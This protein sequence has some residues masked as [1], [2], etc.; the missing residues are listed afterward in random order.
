MARFR[1]TLAI[2]KRVSHHTSSEYISADDYSVGYSGDLT[3][4]RITDEARTDIIPIRTLAAGTWE[5]VEYL[6]EEIYP[7]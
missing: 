2:D 6:P 4:C 5:A 1:V 3:F 7:S